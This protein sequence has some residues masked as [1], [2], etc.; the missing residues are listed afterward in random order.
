MEVEDRLENLINSNLKTM[1][2]KDKRYVNEA[3]ALNDVWV[4]LAKNPAIY[5]RLNDYFRFMSSS[6]KSVT[7]GTA[8]FTVPFQR[9]VSM[10]A[11]LKLFN[12]K[13]TVD[14]M[15]DAVEKT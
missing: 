15:V 13:F 7:L 14:D 12:D 5:K 2:G 4:E 8:D 9:V 3:K 6:R 1:E 11:V 10:F